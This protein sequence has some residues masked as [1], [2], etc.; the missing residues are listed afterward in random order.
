[1]S[2]SL[3]RMLTVVSLACLVVAAT[4][5]LPGVIG[6]LIL[7]F[8]SLVLFPVFTIVGLVNTRGEIQ[9]WFLGA[10]V[11]MVPVYWFNIYMAFVGGFGISLGGSDD[12]S[13][14]ILQLVNYGIVILGGVAGWGS[15][16]FLG[17]HSAKRN[18]D[19]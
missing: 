14:R 4:F 6:A 13:L 10:V 12:F 2:F 9:S 16:R 3:A 5:S 15:Y 18:L 17:L 1:M 7:I 8:V 19:D 11:S